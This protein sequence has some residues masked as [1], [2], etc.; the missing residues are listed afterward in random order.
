MGQFCEI[1]DTDQGYYL[2]KAN[3]VMV[4]FAFWLIIPDY[5]QPKH[6]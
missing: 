1:C 3:L 4:F 5:F 6:S 2:I